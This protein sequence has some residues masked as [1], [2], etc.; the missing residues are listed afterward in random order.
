MDCTVVVLVRNTYMGGK[1]TY[2]VKMESKENFILSV[3][4]DTFFLRL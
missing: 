3:M 1:I 4:K 2:P